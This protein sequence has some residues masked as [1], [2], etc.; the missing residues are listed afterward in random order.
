[1][2]HSRGDLG[3]PHLLLGGARDFRFFGYVA[4]LPYERKMP[5]AKTEGEREVD[6]SEELDYRPTA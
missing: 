1:M 4:E 3:H 5:D 6:P 2:F